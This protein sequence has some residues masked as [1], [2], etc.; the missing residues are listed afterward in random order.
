MPIKR[1]QQI[2]LA[3]VAILSLVSA[4][5]DFVMAKAE[6]EAILGRGL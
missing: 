3:S 1:L 2:R 5:Y 4:R 6:L